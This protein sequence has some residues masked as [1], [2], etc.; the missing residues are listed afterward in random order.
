MWYVYKKNGRCIVSEVK[1]K[2]VNE[3]IGQF[4]IESAAEKYL[5]WLEEK[6]IINENNK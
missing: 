4:P 3:I 1:P 6:R 2:I 5:K